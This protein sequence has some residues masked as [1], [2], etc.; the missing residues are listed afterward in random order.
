MKGFKETK[1]T[2]GSNKRWE[3]S[4]MMLPE[5]VERIRQHEI[6]KKKKVK[7][8]FDEQY[9]NELAMKVA[10]A[11]QEEYLVTVC[12]FDEF[13]DIE[14]PGRITKVDQQLRRLKIED[15]GNE[16]EIHWVYFDDVLSIDNPPT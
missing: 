10:E 16:D 15:A 7:P 2:P 8:E 12:I 3:G 13:D 11:Q 1:L 5:H 4:R 14:I 6:D 9:V